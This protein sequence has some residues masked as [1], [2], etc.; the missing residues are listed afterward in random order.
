MPYEQRDQE[1]QAEAWYNHPV[2][3]QNRQLVAENT[4]LK[5]LLRENGISWDPLLILDANDQTCTR[6]TWSSRKRIRTR[7]SNGPATLAPENSRLPTLPVEI[8]LFILEYAMTS[9]HPIIDPLCKLTKDN[10]TAAEKSRGNQIAIGFLATCKAYSVEGSRFLWSNNKFVFTSP[11]ALRNFADLS[12]QHRKNITSIT[13]RVIAR[14]YDDEERPHL[15]PYPSLEYAHE[16]TINLKVVPRVKEQNLARK[17]FRS[18]SWNQ[19]VDFLEALRPPFDPNHPKMQPR[20]R[21]LPSL[22]TLRIDF[23]NF[24]DSFLTP[25][26]GPSIHN[27]ASHDLGSTL[28]ELQLTGVPECT[29]GSEVAAQLSRMVKDDGLVL[30]GDSAFVYSGNRLRPM[31]D[32]SRWNPCWYPKVVRAWKVL[33]DEYARTKAT[34]TPPQP[35]RAHRHDHAGLY[36]M[37]P[38]PKE[39]GH[40]ESPWKER[41]TLFKRVPVRQDSDVRVWV[42]FDRLSGQPIDDDEYDPDED[43]YDVEDL[44]CLHCG[45]MHSPFGDD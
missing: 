8:L 33:A 38:A 3:V 4:R 28:N 7:S 13:L 19:V 27:L 41:R 35:S 40:P 26:G 42:E 16:K 44:I 24:P 36:T 11:Y 29:W 32:R 15:A 1:D 2:R 5:R 22:E 17:G 39:E 34:P 18:Y 12:F 25:P 20:P 31:S 14:Y 9:K 43:E 6:G 30:K 37:P 45:V 10:L 23:V 21:L